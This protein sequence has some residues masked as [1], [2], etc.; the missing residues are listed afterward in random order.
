MKKCAYLAAVAVAAL[1]S[2]AWAQSAGTSRTQAEQLGECFVMKTTGADRLA[3][4]KWILSAM[5][6]VPKLKDVTA[7][8]PAKKDASDRAMAGIFTRLITVDCRS[9]ATPL[10]KSGSTAG[11]QIAGEALGRIAMQ[12]VMSGPEAEEAMGSF[13]KYV[14]SKA[15]EAMTK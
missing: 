15:F 5:G 2:P 9:E 3:L 6:S 1:A 14:D 8:D 10:L 13:V 11:F 12:E 7:I 4:A